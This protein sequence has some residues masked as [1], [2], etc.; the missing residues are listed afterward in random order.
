MAHGR[1]RILS[2]KVLVVVGVVLGTVMV[3][4]CWWPLVEG[5]SRLGLGFHDGCV[6]IY[7]FEPPRQEVIAFI[8]WMYEQEPR[9]MTWWMDLPDSY[10]NAGL[11]AYHVVWFGGGGTV[12]LTSIVLWPPALLALVTGAALWRLGFVARGHWKN[13]LYVCPA[14]GYARAGLAEAAPCPECGLAA[15]AMGPLAGDRIL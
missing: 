11:F 6:E 13:A 7:Y 3:A 4:S 1:N 14:C 8:K 9:R 5:I 10:V 15:G 2:G 12:A